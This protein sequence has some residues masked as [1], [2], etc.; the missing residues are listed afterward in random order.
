MQ[1]F[2]QQS[3]LNNKKSILVK[4]SLYPEKCQLYLIIVLQKFRIY[5]QNSKKINLL[6]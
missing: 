3:S 6:A 2:E 4:H 5:Q 1:H